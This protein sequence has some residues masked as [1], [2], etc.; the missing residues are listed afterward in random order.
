MSFSSEMRTKAVRKQHRCDACPAPIEI[1]QPMIK[2]AGTTDGD[3]GILKYHPECREAEIALNKLHD[4]WSNDEWIGLWD[5]D[6]EDAEWLIEEFPIVAA[7]KGVT[8]DKVA[9]HKAERERS[10]AYWLDQ[11]KRRDAERKETPHVA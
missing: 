6:W 7:R 11:A 4:T 2:W 5:F 9:E 1:G 8:A 3:F 10:A